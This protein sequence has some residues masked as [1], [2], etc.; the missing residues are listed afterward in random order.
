[1]LRAEI[2][3]LTTVPATRIAILIAALS[4][5]FTQ[6]FS[7]VLETNP[8]ENGAQGTEVTSDIPVMDM[9]LASEQLAVLNLLGGGGSI[10]IVLIAVILL[11][12]LAGTSDFRFGGMVA[13]ALAEPRRERI[14]LAKSGATAL[15]GTATGLILAAA[16]I[17]ALI[18]ALILDGTALTATL[19]DIL[20]TLG[21]GVLAI[22]FLSLIGL[23]VGLLLRNQLTAVLVMLSVLVLEPILLG[24]IQLATGTLPI[25]A[26]MMPN[27]LAHAVISAPNALTG[28]AALGAL[29]VLTG[30]LLTGAAFALKRRSL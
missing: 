21:R 12:V 22:T 28:A 20:G 2:L 7:F 9:T 6:L 30:L 19:T 3:K 4:L 11:G 24:L 18:G 29:A 10:G 16:S 25:W 27:T 1:M 8:V 14:V 15:I 26:Q 23:A 13:T 17:I 5:L